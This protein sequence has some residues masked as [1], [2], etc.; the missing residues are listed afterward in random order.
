MRPFDRKSRPQQLLDKAPDLPDLP[1]GIKSGLENLRSSKAAKA[2]LIAAG[3]VAGL[4]AASARISSRR[5]EGETD[6][7]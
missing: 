7:S 4:T 2:G 1:S 6:D 5:K 3:G